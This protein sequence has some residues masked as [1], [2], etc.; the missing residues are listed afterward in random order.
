MGLKLLSYNAII[1]SVVSNRN[2]GKT[3]TFKKRAVKRAL[4]HNKRTLWLR[5]FKDEA[6]ECINEFFSSKDLQKY[7]GVSFY[8]KETNPNGN[9]R[10][11][12]N[13]FLIRKMIKGKWTRWRWF[14]KVFRL[15]A[16]G[17]LRGVDDVDLD[18]IVFDEFTKPNSSYKLYHGNIAKD[19][20]DIFYSMKREHKITCFLIG[21][22]ESI[23]NPIFNF[24]H[25]K[26]PATQSEGIFKYKKG[27]F[28]IQ[29][30]NNKQNAQTQYD[31]NV[32]ILFAGTPYGDYIF[33]NEYKEASAFKQR[34]MPANAV[35]FTQV[36]INNQF[37]KIAS[38]NGCYYINTRIDKSRHLYCD[39]LPNKSRNERMLVNR[40][41]RF[42]VPFIEALA[43]NRVYYDSAVAYENTQP[44]LQWLNVN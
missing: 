8:D 37:I 3:W 39:I 9:L 38:C 7:C 18:T 20:C 27:T 16:A 14:I 13:T 19:F 43:D 1:N 24:F 35:I 4:K 33:K 41:K 44:L 6:K 17:T 23:T 28:I 26:P 34:K 5:L 10:R 22:K 29:Q 25:I 30:I 21:N 42:F 12:G 15:G 32:E 31:K 40:L 11:E 2:F 36:C